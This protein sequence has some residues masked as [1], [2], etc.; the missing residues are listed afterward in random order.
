MSL[1]EQTLIVEI[2]VYRLKD[3]SMGAGKLSYANILSEYTVQVEVVVSRYP[4]SKEGRFFTEFEFE[5]ESHTVL[6]E[7]YKALI[8]VAMLNG[9]EEHKTVSIDTLEKEEIEFI[10]KEINQAF[11][12]NGEWVLDLLDSDLNKEPVHPSEFDEVA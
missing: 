1:F 12:K 11:E 6:S 4:L 5:I 7:D 3:E 10:I 9:Q 2:P 8:H